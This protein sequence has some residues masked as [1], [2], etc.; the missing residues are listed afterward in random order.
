MSEIN[1]TDRF[2][3]IVVNVID[4]LNWKGITVEEVGSGGRVYFGR[5]KPEHNVSIGDKLFIGVKE[6][7]YGVEEMKVEV[8]LY[9]AEDNRLDWTF[10]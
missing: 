10:I 5:T 9:D 2:K 6:L 1:E 4:S 8:S 7:D 3:C